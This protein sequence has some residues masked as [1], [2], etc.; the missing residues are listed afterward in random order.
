[1]V[2]EER[3]VV[4]TIKEINHQKTILFGA[5][6]ML[7][8]ALQEVF[9]H[10]KF[11]GHRIIDITDED[12]IMK[13]MKREHPAIVINAAAYTDVDGCEDNRVH[14][15]AVNGNGPG[16][17]A[18][19]CTEVDAI[20]VHFSTDYIFD[21]TKTEYR[22]DDRPN[23]INAYGESKLLGEGS[24]A[25][26][27]E[28]YRI[29]RTSWMYGSHGKNFV[30]TILT[31]SRQMPV[32]RV[33]N[34][35]VGKP[36]YTVDLANKVPAIIS[37]DPGVYHI[38]NDGQCSWYEFASAFIPNAIPCSTDEFPRKAKRPAYSVLANTKTLPLRHWKEAVKEYISNKGRT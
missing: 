10:A 14:A 4:E 24:I 27:M 20:L 1:M 18:K 12:A 23:P 6:G 16:Y 5:H 11:V 15:F 8:H 37:C 35:Q 38:T 36:T 7:G 19:A 32:V 2:Y 21:G 34:D 13:H 33:V 9:P 22:E 26:N 30:D 3:M 25:K 28:N 17:I 31:L 29:I